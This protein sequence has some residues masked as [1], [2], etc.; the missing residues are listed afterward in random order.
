MLGGSTGAG[1]AQ[2]LREGGLKTWAKARR[3][4]QRP[5]SLWTPAE[6]EHGT[7]AGVCSTGHL[8]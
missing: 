8:T 1:Q 2:P 7:W 3:A 6:G 4:S 5:Q